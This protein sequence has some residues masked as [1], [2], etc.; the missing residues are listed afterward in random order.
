MPLFVCSGFDADHFVGIGDG[1]IIV[2]V[3]FF[4]LVDQLHAAMKRADMGADAVGGVRSAA[5]RR[6]R[7]LRDV[8]HG[9]SSTPRDRGCARRVIVRIP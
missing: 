1:A 2:L 5:G 9:R 7:A 6:V 4:D 8:A 3:A